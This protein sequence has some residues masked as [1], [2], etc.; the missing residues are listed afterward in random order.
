MSLKWK[1]CGMKH[2]ENIKQVLELGPDYMGFIFYNKSP[3]YVGEQWDGPGRDFPLTTKKVGVFVNESLQTI[4]LL[5]DRYQFDYLQL[6]GHETPEYCRELRQDNFTLIKAVAL[7]ED[8][9]LNTLEDYQP[10]IK[11]FLFDTPSNQFGGTGST[12]DWS[13]LKEYDHEVP[14][15]LGGGI[16]L[17]NIREVQKLN[18]LNLHAIDVNSRFETRPGWKDPVMLENLKN[19]IQEL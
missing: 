19:Q 11:Y 16:S 3:R 4:R 12:F 9:E 1:V 6:H 7:N 18:E 13:V 10:W 2:A 5:A 8:D 15:F 14:F 17:N